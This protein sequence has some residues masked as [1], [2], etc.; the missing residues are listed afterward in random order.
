LRAGEALLR[1]QAGNNWA[2]GDDIEINDACLPLGKAVRVRYHRVQRS[3]ALEGGADEDDD[4]GSGADAGLA[5]ALEQAQ[6][7]QA[8]SEKDAKRSRSAAGKSGASFAS[9]SVLVSR[10]GQGDAEQCLSLLRDVADAPEAWPLAPSSASALRGAV[11][12][13]V[14]LGAGPASGDGVSLGMDSLAALGAVHVGDARDWRAKGKDSAGGAAMEGYDVGA[15][16]VF[17]VDGEV[18]RETRSLA[19]AHNDTEATGSGKNKNKSTV[20]DA[21]VLARTTRPASLLL[22]GLQGW[23]WTAITARLGEG[24]ATAGGNSTALWPGQPART[25]TVAEVVGVLEDTCGVEKEGKESNKRAV[26]AD[27][28]LEAEAEA[29]S[30]AIMGDGEGTLTCFAATYLRV[31]LRAMRLP[32]DARLTI[33]AP[34]AGSQDIVAGATTASASV[35]P[36]LPLP[37]DS[38]T[39]SPSLAVPASPLASPDMSSA[40]P[41][42][43][44]AWGSGAG[45]ELDWGDG[46]M[47]TVVNALPWEL[48][49]KTD[50][51]RYVTHSFFLF[52]I[53]FRTSFSISFF[54]LTF[55]VA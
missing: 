5:W 35:S 31:L 48:L 43:A 41:A 42:S 19:P 15:R 36:A 7:G 22:T 46:Y 11:L 29:E 39:M 54:L 3:W 37:T 13:E 20:A 10:K 30:M 24:N 50:D 44:D 32:K 27:A 33:P 6:A 16:D 1:Q 52:S 4:A 9:S 55:T 49:P 23:P 51:A 25:V 2:D 47:A 45:S 8:H 34:V 38:V 14:T 28:E 18:V 17:F 26:E 12:T 21:R 40:S 53:T